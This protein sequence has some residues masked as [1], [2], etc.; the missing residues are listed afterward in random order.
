MDTTFTDSM[1]FKNYCLCEN[2]YMYMYLQKSSFSN[3]EL[4]ADL[5]AD[6][7]TRTQVYCSSEHRR[8]NRQFIHKC[9]MVITLHGDKVEIH[10]N[11]KIIKLF[12]ELNN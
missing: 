6:S 12:K 8:T 7:D 1:Q 4:S 2:A 3:A 10:L 11:G 9:F 5:Q